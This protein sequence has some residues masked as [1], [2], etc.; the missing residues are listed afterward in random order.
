[1]KGNYRKWNALS[2]FK[3]KNPERVPLSVK[4]K[5]ENPEKENEKPQENLK[6]RRKMGRR[7]TDWDHEW[8]L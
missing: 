3:P 8:R 7:D 5:M 6:Q 4:W 2:C 1:M